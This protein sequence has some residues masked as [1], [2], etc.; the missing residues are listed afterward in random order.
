MSDKQ[1]EE[2]GNKGFSLVSEKFTWNASAKKM[3][4]LYTWLLGNSE[5][6]DFV[7]I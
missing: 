7:F 1:R 2:I 5:K 3:I 6:P 4:Q